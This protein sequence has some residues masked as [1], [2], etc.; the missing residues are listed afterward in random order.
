MPFKILLPVD[1]SEG[2]ARAARHVA[3]I[4]KMVPE[5][6]VH[7]VNVQPLGDDWMTRRSF[8]PEELA[9][10]EQE[11]AEA[12]LAPARGILQAVGI[13]C[14]EHVAQGE[15]APTIARLAKELGCDQ[16]VMGSRGQSSLGGLLMGSVATKV[17]HLADVPVTFVK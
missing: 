17:L 3:G 6:T 10:M 12:A 15:A 16:I 9:K 2:A 5:L 1:G 13:T 14:T 4:A 8:K 11:W 7:L